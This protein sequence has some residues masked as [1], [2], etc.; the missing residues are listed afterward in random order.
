MAKS[1][2]GNGPQKRNLI[3]HGSY[4]NSR[5]GNQAFDKVKWLQ[6]QMY[7]NGMNGGS[8][9]DNRIDGKWGNQSMTMANNQ[10]WTIGSG[11]NQL[12]RGNRIWNW[13]P[14]SR[15]YVEEIS[16]PDQIAN[17]E[18]EDKRAAED[19]LW[20]ILSDPRQREA[21]NW[22][23]RQQAAGKNVGIADW[24]IMNEANSHSLE[25]AIRAG[26][27]EGEFVAGLMLSIAGP[28]AL[29]ALSKT[30]GPLLSKAI[31]ATGRGIGKGLSV[32]NDAI[33]EGVYQGSRLFTEPSKVMGQARSAASS[34]AS[35][36]R[37]ALTNA[38]NSAKSTAQKVSN[39]V[40]QTGAKA[41]DAVRNAGQR[42]SNDI[43]SSYKNILRRLNQP[44]PTTSLNRS[45]PYSSDQPFEEFISSYPNLKNGGQLGKFQEGGSLGDDP[46]TQLVQAFMQQ[47]P[48]AIQQ[49]QQIYQ[50]AQ[51]GDEQAIQ[52]LQQIQQRAKEMGTP[53]AKNGTKLNYIQRL[54]G[55]CPEGYELE[56]FKAGGKVCSKCMK[57]AAKANK[58]MENG[59]SADPGYIKA[60]KDKCGAKM[61]KK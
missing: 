51:Q 20:Y 41:V 25:N 9:I 49:I 34:A 28:E 32:A 50:A 31:Q 22:I 7:A 15:S 48:Q 38:S 46:I 27:I 5:F 45:T 29:G 21:Q 11:G 37:S 59:G 54:R 44:R 52:L 35:R 57:K 16:Y 53:M 40:K 58:K 47:D 2:I 3:K 60:F 4:N 19:E 12:M 10:G 56:Y 43:T 17:W 14:N 13:D 23:N 26:Q 36:T 33:E 30:A 1:Q 8:V 42:V 61:K 6:N 55:K 39:S 18:N 24:F